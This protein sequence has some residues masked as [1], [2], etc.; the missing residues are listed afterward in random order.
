[1]YYSVVDEAEEIYSKNQEE[2]IFHQQTGPKMLQ[3]VSGMR[4]LT[5]REEQRG[6][7]NST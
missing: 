6:L 5:G 1:M 3:D 2:P 4:P 7:D